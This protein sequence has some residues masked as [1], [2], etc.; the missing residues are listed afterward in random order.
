MKFH[1]KSVIITC[2]L[3][4][5]VVFLS[6]LYLPD[7]LSIRATA[8]AET[9]IQIVDT[10]HLG[11]S[12][13]STATSETEK[14][15]VPPETEAP[16]EPP[17]HYTEVDAVILAKLLWEECRGVKG[18]YC[19]V[20]A[21]A[22]QAGVA[23]TVLNRLDKGN[24][25]SSL[26]DVVTAPNQYAYNPQAP[27]DEDLLW[28]ANDVLSRWNREQNGETNVGRTI[29]AEYLYF[30]GDGQENHFRIGYKDKVNWNWSLPDP[31]ATPDT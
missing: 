5:A 11:P 21:K 8:A 13:D 20:S 10:P 19:G 1:R 9:Q 4:A 3:L 12:H 14:P 2:L 29:P 27:V 6:C 15:T 28:L 25:G 18:I 17:M 23:W 16:A 24:Y 30:Y 7:A 22:R 31:Y 26:L